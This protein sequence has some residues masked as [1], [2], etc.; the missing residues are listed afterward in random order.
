MNES[1]QN[2]SK[3]IS[4]RQVLTTGCALIAGAVFSPKVVIA[5]STLVQK[6]SEK[7]IHFYNTHTGEFFKGAYWINGHFIPEAM[8]DLNHFLRDWRTN[9]KIAINPKLFD[10]LH[11]LSN[12]LE[13][14][15]PF[16]IICG[17]RTSKTNEN[18]R[19]VKTGIAKHSRHLTGDAI[20]FRAPGVS[21]KDLRN[22]ALV[23]KAG[24]VGYYPK[25]GF[26]HIDIRD[27]PASW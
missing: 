24:G 8:N 19:Q 4:R 10:V 22:A 21:L 1:H 13:T 20:D 12:S 11:K 9:D 18:L 16:E 25:S 2:D 14:K 17:Y 7:F 23:E 3:M 5:G 6:V 15:K 27:K 26:I